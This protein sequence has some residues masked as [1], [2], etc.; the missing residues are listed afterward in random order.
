MTEGAADSLKGGACPWRG[1]KGSS[2]ALGRNE[3]GKVAP[4][5]TR[6]RQNGLFGLRTAPPGTGKRPRLVSQW[7]VCEKFGLSS[8]GNL[9]C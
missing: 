8:S 4:S 6:R 9:K 1:R 7:L 5:M 2:V 3:T